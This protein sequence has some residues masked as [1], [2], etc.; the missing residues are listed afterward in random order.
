MSSKAYF[1]ERRLRRIK[2]GKCQDCPKQR[3]YGQLKCES[4]AKKCRIRSASPSVRTAQKL[5]RA[6]LRIR[7]LK[8]YGNKCAC[9]QCPE[10][11]SAFLTIDHINNDG[12]K[13][14]RLIKNSEDLYRWIIKHDFPKDLQ[15]LCFNCN[16][17][18]AAHGGPLHIC[19]HQM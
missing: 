2:S 6:A 14:R 13:H 9:P 15:L 1:K 12:A 11:N 4:C 17:G 10:T 16:I 5:R 3:L 19:P 18:R 8:Y 7:I